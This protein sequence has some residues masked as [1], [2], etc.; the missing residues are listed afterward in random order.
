MLK[1]LNTGELSFRFVCFYLIKFTKTLENCAD[2][3][4]T[5]YVD[6]RYDPYFYK[7]RTPC[8]NYLTERN[9]NYGI[10]IKGCGH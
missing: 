5:V 3:L 2:M 1:K 6:R 7:I 9:C 10:Q 4:Y 8:G